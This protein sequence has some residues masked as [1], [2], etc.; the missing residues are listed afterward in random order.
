MAEYAATK[1]LDAAMCALNEVVDR[2]RAIKIDS[3]TCLNAEISIAVFGE[4][5]LKELTLESRRKPWQYIVELLTSLSI[6]IVQTEAL[7][8]CAL[9]LSCIFLRK[10]H[11]LGCSQHGNLKI[12]Q[13]ISLVLHCAY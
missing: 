11:S 8:V 6:A 4:L 5:P 1:A 2:I 7:E 10:L 3:N 12:V 13:V 9:C